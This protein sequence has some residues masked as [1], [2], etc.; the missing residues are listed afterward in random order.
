M[1]NVNSYKKTAAGVLTWI[2]AGQKFCQYFPPFWTVVGLWLIVTLKI[3]TGWT[4][5]KHGTSDYCVINNNF[6][7]RMRESN[8]E[9]RSVSRPASVAV[10][11]RRATGTTARAEIRIFA[12]FIC[13]SPQNKRLVAVIEAVKSIKASWICAKAV[14]DAYCLTAYEVPAYI[15]FRVWESNSPIKNVW[16][17]IEM[18]KVWKNC[19]FRKK[20]LPLSG[21]VKILYVNVLNYADCK[22]NL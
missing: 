18:L 2:A 11:E 19:D 7:R 5:Y 15:C 4:N 22:Y 3:Y 9:E 21:V 8:N 14:I 17:F 1:H 12:A 16:N 20:S 6:S 13:R 10:H